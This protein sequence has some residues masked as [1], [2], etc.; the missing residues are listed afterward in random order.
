LSDSQPEPDFTIARGDA[1]AYL[2]RHPTV[3]DVILV[4]EVAHSSL[5]RDQREKTRIYARAGVAVYWI[6]NLVDR[7]V[8]VYTQPSGATAAPAYGNVQT[9]LPSDTISLVLDGNTLAIPVNELLP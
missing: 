6:I 7:R 5:L 2:H 3:A 1:R 9:F 4:I 8:E